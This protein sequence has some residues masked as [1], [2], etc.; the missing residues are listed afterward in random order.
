MKVILNCFKNVFL[1]VHISCSVLVHFCYWHFR[2]SGT[3]TTVKGT[4]FLWFWKAKRDPEL[5]VLIV[6]ESSGWGG[7]AL[8]DPVRLSGEIIEKAVR[9][10]G[11]GHEPDFTRRQDLTWQPEVSKHLGGAENQELWWITTRSSQGWTKWNSDSIDS[12][13]LASGKLLSLES[14]WGLC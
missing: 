8:A 10:W 14:C 2:T 9:R 7:V 6:G 1:F 5:R 13:L 12:L 11:G 3:S 4:G